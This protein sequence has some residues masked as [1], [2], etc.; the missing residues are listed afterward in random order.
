MYDLALTRCALPNSCLNLDQS[1][2]LPVGRAATPAAQQ[3]LEADP[4]LALLDPRCLSLVRWAND[5]SFRVEY[6]VGNAGWANC[7]VAF[8]D[9]VVDMTASYL[10]DSL[11][12]LCDVVASIARGARSGT[13]VFV[14]EPGEH[15]LNLTRTG[16]SD[17]SVQIVWHDEWTS[18][19]IGAAVK[20]RVI[21]EETTT[22]AHLRGQTYSAARAVLDSLGPE[23]Y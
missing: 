5:M 18:W 15:H 7:R 2:D 17:V 6:E 1:S 4:D 11:H 12:Q 19:G 14:D 9:L 10:H 22:V 3:R 16:E 21:L 13:V 20:S 8:G 23:E